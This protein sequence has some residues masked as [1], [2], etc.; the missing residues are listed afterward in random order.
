MA[1][2]ANRQTSSR[3]NRRRAHH[4]LKK[5]AVSYCP[6]CKEAMTPHVACK[7]CGFYNGREV[8]D[9]FAKLDK[10]EKK[11]KEKAIESHDHK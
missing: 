3:K 9:V 5:I 10:K 11:K 7:N 4:S 8:I 6:K 2:P 1:V